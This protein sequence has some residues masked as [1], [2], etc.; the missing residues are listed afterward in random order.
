VEENVN[1][2]DALLLPIKELSEHSYECQVIN[3]G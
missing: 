3:D 1:Q 2:A